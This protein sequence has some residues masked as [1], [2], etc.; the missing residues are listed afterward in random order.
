MIRVEHLSKKFGNTEVLRDVNAHINRGEVISVIGPSGTG[1]STFLRC[2]NLLDP[3]TGGRIFIEEQEITAPNA[4]VSR[5]RQKMGMVF[6]DFN[7]FLHLNVL[8][9]LTIAPVKLLGK[10]KALA[11]SKARELLH[12]VGLAAKEKA[13]PAELS[14]GQKQRVA[15]ARCLAMDPD[16]ILFD[17][18]TSALD[19]TMVS[20]VLGVI[21]RLAG[22]GMTMVIVT[23]EMQFARDVSS[24]VFYMDQGVIYE[25]GP[26]SRIFDHPEKEATR[27]FINRIRN[28]E[29]HIED[30]EHY[31]I[32]AL[33]AEIIQFC[34]K[35]FLG[36]AQRDALIHLAEETLQMCLGTDNTPQTLTRRE[37]IRETGGIN[38][39]I[40]YSEKTQQIHTR[41][42]AHARL[43][44]IL[45]NAQDADGL[46]MM[47][48]NGI[49]K[50]K[51]V[52][53]IEGDRVVLDL[54]L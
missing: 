4:N 47:I 41:F 9:N 48:I 10:T 44:T 30:Y 24:R 54:P 53:K 35:H 18:P 21:R 46:G 50:G 20:E 25:E 36:P 42:T 26:P 3:P 37:I 13:Y 15:I 27:T 12:M 14:G 40:S 43:E 28:L 45:N 7:L 17:E 23:H 52:E 2:L 33:T 8:E 29:W 39:F 22:T 31:D 34:E 49:T 6:Q 16:I 38:L 51:A 5:L 1:K 11:E 32:Y 19:P